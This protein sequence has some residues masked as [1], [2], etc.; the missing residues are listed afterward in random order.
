[1]AG[2]FEL[3]NDSII[4]ATFISYDAPVAA[5]LLLD[6]LTISSGVQ[7]YRFTYGSLVLS[8]AI[9]PPLADPI[10]TVYLNGASGAMSA[11]L[12]LCFGPG[13]TAYASDGTHIFS[14]LAFEPSVVQSQYA[15]RVSG[16]GV[17]SAD[18]LTGDILLR[19]GY[20]A[21]LSFSVARNAIRFGASE[22]AGSG[23]P[24]EQITPAE[25]GCGAV[26]Y[27]VNGI[28]PDAFGNFNISG[29]LGII[30]T[31]VPGQNKIQMR[32][33]VRANRPSCPDEK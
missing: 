15:S 7:T 19:A 31:P 5:A 28:P 17:S 30:V 26:Q 4:D 9:I 3:T 12:R 1:M 24:C 16:L 14:G 13:V 27:Y 22:G 32:T 20:N 29:G 33:T 21:A 10:A 8:L 6:R 25:P 11:M 23:V 18:L 2:S